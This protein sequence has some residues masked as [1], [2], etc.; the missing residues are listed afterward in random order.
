M[1]SAPPGHDDAAPLACRRVGRLGHDAHAGITPEVAHLLEVVD[2]DHRQD[3]R[4][5]QEPH[6]HRQ[7]R[8][9]RLHGGQHGHVLGG[10]KSL[11]R[12]DG[13]DSWAAHSPRH[14][15]NDLG[16]HQLDRAHRRRMVHPRLLGL[17]QQVADAELALHVGE[18]VGDLVGR[19]GD[20][21]VLGDQ[22]LVAHR[23]QRAR[24]RLQRELRCRRASACRAAR[25]TRRA[26]GASGPCATRSTG[27]PR[28]PSP[29]CRR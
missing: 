16:A 1:N 4:I 19:A 14:R 3:R 13:R 28:A 2:A 7:R 21:E 9:V 17:Q 5:V 12:P 18:P 15:G 24:P 25:S 11:D 27:R 10:E 22:L 6:R 8:A 26:R 20:D 23:G 29:S